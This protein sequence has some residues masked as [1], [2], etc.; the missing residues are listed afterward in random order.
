MQKNKI[1]DSDLEK[2]LQELEEPLLKRTRG[3]DDD[4]DNEEIPTAQ[5]N[6]TIVVDTD[7]K[8]ID[9]DLQ[10]IEQNQE[11]VTIENKKITGEDINV[12]EFVINIK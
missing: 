6:H 8:A 3:T 9:L 4:A 7:E 1:Q 2:K 12:M 10:Q 5:K 11:K